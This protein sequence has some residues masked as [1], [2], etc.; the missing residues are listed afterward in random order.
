MISP[1]E[2]FSRCLLQ[3]NEYCT[4]YTAGQ[5]RLTGG[6]HNSLRTRL[7]AALVYSYIGRGRD[8]WFNYKAVIYKQQVTL[9]VQLNEKVVGRTELHKTQRIIGLLFSCSAGILSATGRIILRRVFFRNE[10]RKTLLK[11]STYLSLRYIYALFSVR[12]NFCTTFRDYRDNFAFH[13]CSFAS[14]PI[15]FCVPQLFLYTVYAISDTA[16]LK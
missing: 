13:C 14:F 16:V 10:W 9:K 8:N 5:L 12:G 15:R 7:R 1:R 2:R 6:P 11:C 4:Y 3:I